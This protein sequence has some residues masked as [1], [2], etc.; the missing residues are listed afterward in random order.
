MRSWN[1][2]FPLNTNITEEVLFEPEEPVIFIHGKRLIPSWRLEAPSEGQ[3]PCCGALAAEPEAEKRHNESH[4]QAPKA[5]F[6][7]GNV[8]KMTFDDKPAHNLPHDEKAEHERTQRLET[9]MQPPGK[10]HQANGQQQH[11]A[12]SLP[13]QCALLFIIHV[14][15]RQKSESGR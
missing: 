4:R 8:P 1:K 12:A 6:L 11:V 5:D 13:Q 7:L 9:I 3:L 15:A 10:H 2:A 14:G